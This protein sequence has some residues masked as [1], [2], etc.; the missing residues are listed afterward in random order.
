MLGFHK[1]LEATFVLIYVKAQSSLGNYLET[2]ILL[3]NVVWK[4]M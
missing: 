4:N 1:T 3:M 2:P